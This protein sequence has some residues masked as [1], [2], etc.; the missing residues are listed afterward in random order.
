MAV[1]RVTSSWAGLWLGTSSNS[2]KT[3]SENVLRCIGHQ[4]SGEIK[5]ARAPIA[6]EP[7]VIT[8]KARLAGYYGLCTHL[9]RASP[10]RHQ[11]WWVHRLP[12]SFQS[13]GS[14]AV[15]APTDLV[16]SPG[17]DPRGQQKASPQKA[18]GMWQGTAAILWDIQ[19]LCPAWARGTSLPKGDVLGGR[20]I[21]RPSSL[22]VAGQPPG[23]LSL[24]LPKDGAMNSRPGPFPSSQDTAAAPQEPQPPPLLRRLLPPQH[25]ARVLPKTAVALLYSEEYHSAY[26]IRLKLTKEM[27]TI[28]KQD[29]ICVGGSH[30]GRNV[31]AANS[32]LSRVCQTSPVNGL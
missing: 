24:T 18:L 5:A 21:R 13:C 4:G 9:E 22:I 12:V 3:C 8:E 31:S 16:I 30:R 28:Q 23:Q 17:T 11:S 27:L 6:R 1:E 7:W 19:A 14:T 20:P 25:H 10:S 26:D 32:G 15:P 29:V 2:V